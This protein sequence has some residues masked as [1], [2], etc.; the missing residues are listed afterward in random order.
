MGGLADW[1]RDLVPE[2]MKPY[3]W[4]ALRIYTN[5]IFYVMV[6]VILTVEVLRPAIREQ[7]VLSRS[8]AQDFAW[9]NL[10]TAFKVAALPA[11]LAL[12]HAGYDRLTGGYRV[13]A[14]STWPA[15][16]RVSAAFLLFDFLQWFHHWVRHKVRP[17]WEFHVIHHSQREMNL[18]TDVR[19][20]G[21]EYFIAQ[22][23]T[24]VPLLAFQ[25]SAN[26]IMGLSAFTLW[27]TR[28]YHANIR[29]NFGPLRY[30][31][32]TPQ[33]HRIHHSIEPR[34]RDRN[35]S[36]I[37]TVWDRLFGT[38]YPSY[39]EYPPTGVE[40]VEFR[41][42]LRGFRDEIVYPFRKIFTGLSRK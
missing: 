34:H 37:L 23:I 15:W 41:T 38:L 16:L 35:F 36:V 19:V 27:Y 25:L 12:L 1:I 32:V 28:L 5:P 2:F 7:R 40:G 22:T 33:S 14:W 21:V 17:F 8:L 6:A 10:D 39:D 9:F 30:L 4:A 31:L 26:A 18:F 3:Y 29:S 24:I 13:Q 11:F 20:H 42:G